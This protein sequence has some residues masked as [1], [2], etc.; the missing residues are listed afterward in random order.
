MFKEILLYELKNKFSRLSTYLYFL[1]I[2]ACAFL[3][4]SAVGGAFSGASVHI[5]PAGQG[6]VF[7]NT[8]VTIFILSTFLTYFGLF[9]IT[10][11]AGNAACRDFEERSYPLLFTSPVSKFGYFGGR[12]TASFI[13]SSIIM[14]GSLFG[15]WAATLMPY[16][17]P[18]TLGPQNYAMYIQPFFTAILP[19]VFF[20][21]AFF[22]AAGLYTRKMMSIYVSSAVLFMGY[23]IGVNIVAQIKQR[24]IAALVEPFGLMA[25]QTVTE[26][27]TVHD[28]N[29]RLV[30]FTSNLIYNR[31]LWV[32][33]ALIVL[34]IA[35]RRFALKMHKEPREKLT[36]AKSTAFETTPPSVRPN[37]LQRFSFHTHL[38]N[39]LSLLK[40][41]L[42]SIVKN[43]FFAVFAF[44]SV[45]FML[46]IS[47]SAGEMYETQIF[48]VTWA[49]LDITSGSFTM[50]MFLIIIFY[51]GELVW[52]ER[53]TNAAKFIDA[54]P[55]PDWLPFSAKLGTMFCIIAIFQ[56][57]VMFSGMLMQTFKGYFNYEPMLYITSL[58]VIQMPVYWLYA[59]LAV[60]VQ[61]LANNKY[62]GHFYVILILFLN[63][64][65]S[66]FGLEH[67]LY[68]LYSL[69]RFMY[70]DMNGFG[71]T[72]YPWFIYYLYW[73]FFTTLIAFTAY[74]FRIR[75]EAAIGKNRARQALQRFSGS[76]HSSGIIFCA[77]W[78]VV[79]GYIF[80]NTN[81]LNTFSTSYEAEKKQKEYEILYKKYEKTP[82]LRITDIKVT[83][84]LYPSEKRFTV[85]GMYTLLNKRSVPVHEI[86]IQNALRYTSFDYTF[87][88]EVSRSVYNEK[89]GFMIYTLKEPMQPGD[90][91]TMNFKIVSE[92]KGFTHN[93]INSQV[94]AN[95]TFIN[96]GYFPS[97]GYNTH[98]ELQS[99]KYRKKH[100][101]EPKER[102]ASI[103]DM[104]ARMNTYISNDSDWVT[105]DVTVGTEKG[106]IAVAPGN[107][108][109]HRTEGD[110]EYYRY[111]P[112]RKVLHFY[113]IC[114]A[115]FTVTRDKWNDVEIEIYHDK[116]HPYNVARMIDSLKK[117]LDY[118]TANFSPYPD[119]V[120]RIVE[121]PRYATYAQSFPTMIPYSESIGFIAKVT[122]GKV[123][124]PF[125][126]TAHEMAHQ[127]WAH[128]VIGGNV[129]GVT[130]MSE[131]FSQYS[132]LMVTAKEQGTKITNKYLRYDI[133][134]YLRAR[135]R[136]IKKELPL[137][138]NEN[139]GYLHYQKGVVVMNCLQHY[140]GEER[141]NKA[142]AEYCTMTAFQEPPFTV[143]TEFITIL[144]KHVQPE[145]Q[146]LV[147]NLLEK[148]TLYDFEIKKADGE[149]KS[150][151]EYSLA[152]TMNAIKKYADEKGEETDAVITE[153][154]TIVVYNDKDE[155]LYRKK[156]MIQGN[157]VTLALQTAQKP[158]SVV[159]DPD[160][161]FIDRDLQNNKKTV[162]IK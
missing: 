157:N 81:I 48:P 66:Q 20:I 89:H 156:H 92:P 41:Y 16:I 73:M 40:M 24:V 9:I 135:S 19:N 25:A 142:L 136:E 120:I 68:H 86:I 29:T 98:G 119:K 44:I 14:S 47:S 59:V 88:R 115:D 83:V 60:S 7:I 105:Y 146:Q 21:T 27:W 103:D 91:C 87:S 4:M 49:M 121:F 100:G 149:K 56:T 132:A 55:H 39:W 95:G 99:D 102:M 122:K 128:Q 134:S 152:L 33:I 42:I 85:D 36:K 129:Q 77:A 151:S 2:F 32:A 69:P 72:T 64:F 23:L 104:D 116:K 75:G 35:Y 123:D 18:D 17:K 117:S 159:I 5:G 145:Y 62:A 125:N 70:S 1:M 139:Q 57:V 161:L 94:I 80:Y 118:F 26:Y 10:A 141:I 155:E 93:G 45:A 97:L 138:L 96:S 76:L 3:A 58:Y 53:R 147:T 140:I 101:L 82:Q 8:P 50:F 110:R 78:L 154:V 38:Q 46:Y 43:K 127:W 113:A 126:I 90:T 133:D 63:M 137:Y 114:S 160:Y 28:I 61:T 31:I 148:I 130:L 71:N 11:I 65:L 51:S 34:V 150:D 112:Q 124:Y 162:T 107:L 109:E 13:I 22:F 153:P 158:A 74:A 79:G 37:V 15:A 143:S 108:L 67:S 52:F 12:F 6:K 131:V 111:S 54:L 144:R 106:Q 30:P 84:D